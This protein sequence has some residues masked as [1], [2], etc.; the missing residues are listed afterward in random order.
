MWLLH[1]LPTGLLEFFVNFMLFTGL[2]LTLVLFL[3]PNRLLRLLPGL[4]SYYTALQILSVIILTLGV[5]F[6]GGHST[7]LIWRGKVEALEAKV[8][9]AEAKSQ[10]KTVEVQEKVVTETV[11]IREKAKEIIKYV[12]K[13]IDR[14][15]I[16]KEE[17]IK[18]IEHCPVPTEL[19]DIHNQ[20]AELNKVTSG[21]K[22]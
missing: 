4:S 15:V 3:L 12:D 10:E 19:I 7:E 6:K 11:V 2:G 17:I 8:K 21:S 13:F 5:Y 1:L 14:E 9:V 18:Y 16:K 22:K 20:A